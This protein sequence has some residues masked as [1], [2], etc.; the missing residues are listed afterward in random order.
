MRISIFVIF[1]FN[2]NF[3]YASNCIHQCEIGDDGCWSYDNI[4]F[5]G[6]CETIDGC[7]VLVTDTICPAE[8]ICENGACVKK[9][10]EDCHH[11]CREG[12]I[13]CFLNNRMVCDDYD[14]DGCYEWYSF[15]TCT[16]NQECTTNA[17]I[18]IACSNQC[19]QGEKRCSGEKIE[20]C[21][22]FDGDNCLEWS[23]AISCGIGKTC[24]NGVCVN[25]TN[26]TNQCIVNEIRCS[27]NRVE[28]CKLDSSGCY[29]YS[30][31]MICSQNQI[32][33]RGKCLNNGNS[34]V[35]NAGDVINTNS[36]ISGESSSIDSGSPN[37][38]LEISCIN[39]NN[40]AFLLKLANSFANSGKQDTPHN[41]LIKYLLDTKYSQSNIITSTNSTEKISYDAVRGDL[42]KTLS[43]LY[44]IRNTLQLANVK[45]SNFFIR[46][47]MQIQS[48]GGDS[49]EKMMTV[50]KYIISDGVI[51]SQFATDFNCL[52]NEINKMEVVK[53]KNLKVFDFSKVAH[54]DAI[55]LIPYPLDSQYRVSQFAGDI[56][57]NILI[58]EN[59]IFSK[60]ELQ[61]VFASDGAFRNLKIR[62]NKISI[63]GK[64]V[65][66]INGML[67]GEISNNRDLKGVLLNKSDIILNPIRVGGE[68]NIYILGFNNGDRKPNHPDYYIYEKIL[69]T[70]QITDLR[71]QK[72]THGRYYSNWI[73]V[74]MVKLRKLFPSTFSKVQLLQREGKSQEVIQQEWKRMMLQVGKEVF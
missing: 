2:F 34:V 5:V 39:S 12:A 51:N 54:R 28:K 25:L 68:A 50:K 30:Q 29:K 46:D 37:L 45:S 4:D 72:T 13:F 49:P 1:L 55:Q 18:D 41:E 67:S 52:V 17:C 63:K 32:C 71:T 24:R 6:Y 43:P 35:P 31:E 62:N 65:I 69:G 58:D 38:N 20:Q 56:M 66:T 74:D 42:G 40:Q 3:I 57:Q 53:I 64:H 70:Q 11:D 59:S 19:Q 47:F 15:E 7:R 61:G 16:S 33:S 21:G 10:V 73:D 26:C 60:G 44:W 14:N 9:T 48:R 8:D 36:V 27:G 23:E 22:N